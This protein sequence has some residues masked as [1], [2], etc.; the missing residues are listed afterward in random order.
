M[1]I[2]R[3]PPLSDI[4]LLYASRLRGHGQRDGQQSGLHHDTGGLEAAMFLPC[5]TL[6]DTNRQEQWESAAS[7]KCQMPQAQSDHSL[8]GDSTSDFE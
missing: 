6:L 1:N 4:S 3:R 8:F 5:R 2:R 7:V